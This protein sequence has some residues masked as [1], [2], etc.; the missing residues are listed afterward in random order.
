MRD[1]IIKILDAQISGARD[2]LYRSK[3]QF[4]NS[5]LNSEYGQSGRKCGEILQKDY[6]E[7]SKLVKMRSWLIAL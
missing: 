1:E 3:M 2:N 5:D 6:D 4:R 7:L